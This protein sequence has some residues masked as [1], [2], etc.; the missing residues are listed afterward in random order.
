MHIVCTGTCLHIK[1]KNSLSLSL[2]YSNYCLNWTTFS[3]Y[4]TLIVFTISQRHFSFKKIKFQDL[5]Y[6]VAVLVLK[7]IHVYSYKAYWYILPQ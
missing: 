7:H 1:V 2:S 5:K 3:A 6:T 4:K